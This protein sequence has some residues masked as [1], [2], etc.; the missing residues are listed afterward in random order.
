MLSMTGYGRGSA[1]LGRTQVIVEARSVNHRFL[2]VKLRLSGALADHGALV[3][4]C[5]RRCMERGRVEV[6]ARIETEANTRGALNEALIRATFHQLRSLR[7]ELSPHEPLPWSLLVAM[8]ELFTSAQLGAPE[9]VAAALEQAT[10][11]ACAQL[12]AMH[13]KEGEKLRQDLLGRLERARNIV[14]EVQ[15]RSLDLVERCRTRLFD[16]LSRVCL[17]GGGSVDRERLEQEVVMYADRSDIS[18]ELTR[19]QS[20]FEHFSGLL[21]EGPGAVGRRLDFLLQEMGRET[22]TLGSKA[23]SVETTPLVVELKAELERMREQ[24]QN[25][26]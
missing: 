18:E 11:S 16:R 6:G 8:P 26:L 1:V 17:P 4:D 23:A 20:H 25:V 22:N 9:Q 3:E 7:D 10:E 15:T 21:C 5:V 13:A 2:D 24:V 19:M 12:S 14:G